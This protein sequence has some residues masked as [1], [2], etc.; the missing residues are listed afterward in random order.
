MGGKRVWGFHIWN[1][2]EGASFHTDS[3]CKL[4]RQVKILKNHGSLFELLYKLTRELTYENIP[5]TNGICGLWPRMFKHSWKFSSL[6]ELLCKLT[7]ELTFRNIT[8][9]NYTGGLW[10]QVKIP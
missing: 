3:I 1:I 8:H 10:Q 7:R 4:W 5:N 2:W 6:L 9:T